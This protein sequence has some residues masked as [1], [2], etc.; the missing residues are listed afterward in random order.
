[1]PQIGWTHVVSRNELSSPIIKEIMNKPSYKYTVHLGKTLHLFWVSCT[2]SLCTLIFLVRF[3]KQQQKLT[4]TMA[5]IARRERQETQHTGVSVLGSIAPFLR[6]SFR[7]KKNKWY[8][9]LGVGMSDSNRNRW[10]KNRRRLM[11][12]TKT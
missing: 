4:K 10:K 2:M 12:F 7:I 9:L 1:M 11:P 6:S 8:V 3:A 5:I